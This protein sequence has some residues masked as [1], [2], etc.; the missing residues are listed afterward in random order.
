[1]FNLNVFPRHLVELHVNS[2]VLFCR[3]V[4]RNS[5]LS[6]LQTPEVLLLERVV[7]VSQE[8][9]QGESRVELAG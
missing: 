1:M 8:V 9:Q 3:F 7:S 5:S 2:A 4:R 6:V